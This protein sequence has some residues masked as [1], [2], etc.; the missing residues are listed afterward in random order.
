MKL[1][2]V[3]VHTLGKN[4]GVETMMS[5]VHVYEFTDERACGQIR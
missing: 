5:T 2:N 3:C 1:W 4:L